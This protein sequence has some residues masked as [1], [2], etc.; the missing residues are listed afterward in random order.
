MKTLGMC[1]WAVQLGDGEP[2]EWS[3]IVAEVA[4]PILGADF[5]AHHQLS[6][7]IHNQVLR[8]AAGMMMMI[9]VLGRVDC[10]DHFAPITTE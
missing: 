6:V 8:D 2:L 5:L 7:N 10:K 3:F 1:R 4:S 9:G